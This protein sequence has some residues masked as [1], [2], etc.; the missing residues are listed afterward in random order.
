MTA[1]VKRKRNGNRLRIVLQKI[2]L[3]A[4]LIVGIF[5]VLAT[6]TG[7]ISMFKNDL[8][9]LFYS[10]LF[11]VTPS[12]TPVSLDEARATAMN[13]Y[14]DYELVDVFEK[15]G[16]PYY[17]GFVTPEDDYL[18]AYV[19]PGTGEVNGIY[20]PD[21]TPLGVVEH[22]HE[23]LLADGIPYTYTDRT[24]MW[25]Q[26][27]LG[28][29][30]GDTIQKFVSFCFLI[31]VLTGAYLWWPGIKKLALSFKLRLNKSEYLKHYDWHKILGFVSLPF[32][33]MWAITSLNFFTPFSSVISNV[34]HTLT[35]TEEVTWED[36]LFSTVIPGQDIITVAEVKSIAAQVVPGST[37]TGYSPTGGEDGVIYVWLKKGID[38]FAGAPGPGNGYIILDAYSG[39]VLYNYFDN[40][41]SV[42]AGLY[43]NWFFAM[44][45]G[46]AVPWWGRLVWAVFGLVPLF[47]AI[48]GV[49]MWWLK[50]TKRMGHSSNENIKQETLSS[51]GD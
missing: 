29:H 11:R 38:A 5:L 48:T 31:M 37:F 21:K 32:L 6:V 36:E 46:V 17:F 22:F 16:E 44:H 50:R 8:N 24:P 39:E 10:S 34:W 35:F 12:S 2:H 27:W 25:I 28:E 51:T 7:T 13:A 41:P 45:T 20:N 40:V 14:P 26:D 23:D 15:A 18:R 47:L 30:V 42:A 49:S 9:K 33:L 19:D 1:G 4:A 43:A 3:W